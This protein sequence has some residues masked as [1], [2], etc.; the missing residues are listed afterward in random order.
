MKRILA[1]LIFL[2]SFNLYSMEFF[3]GKMIKTKHETEATNYFLSIQREGK[4]LVFP[5]SPESKTR[6]LHK[7]IGKTVR[8]SG[9]T[10]LRK[11]ARSETNF[12]MYIN[13]QKIEKLSLRDLGLPKNENDFSKYISR[14]QRKK[15]SKLTDK[16]RK[17]MEL[18]DKAYNTA[19]FV[20]GAIL[21]A[22]IL[23]A[24]K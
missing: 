16:E 12:L 6:N 3:T 18:S 23:G 5:I 15:S 21:A 14:S 19:I 17:A 4:K 20:G 11:S 13:V 22:E 8:L 1:L 24:L 10:Q 7:Y 9:K 2:A